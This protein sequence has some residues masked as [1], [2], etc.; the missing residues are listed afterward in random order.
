M[1]SNTFPL[2]MLSSKSS[3][4]LA[5]RWD[6]RAAVLMCSARLHLSKLSSNRVNVDRVQVHISLLEFSGRDLL[7]E[8]D[9]EFRE[10]TAFGLGKAEERPDEAQKSCSSPHE[11]CVTM[12]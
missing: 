1:S 2:S 3:T 12:D 5:S 4:Q 10:R 8:Q 6:A 9:I 7:F 11:A